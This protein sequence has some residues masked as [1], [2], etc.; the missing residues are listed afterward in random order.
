MK[1]AVCYRYLDINVSSD[2]KINEEG[3]HRIEEGRKA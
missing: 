3:S 1:E 2:G